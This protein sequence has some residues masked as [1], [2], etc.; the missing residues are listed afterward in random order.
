MRALAIVIA[1]V[2]LAG[3]DGLGRPI[4][5]TRPVRD[6]GTDESCE[7]TPMCRPIR[8]V[9]PSAFVVPPHR[10]AAAVYA[11]CDQD[12][13]A[14]AVD[15]CPGVANEDQRDVCEVARAECERLRSGETGRAYAD[16]RG[17]RLEGPTPVGQGFSLRGA[18]LQCAALSLVAV[19]DATLDLSQADLTRASLELESATAWVA[20]ATRA[21]LRGTFVRL[22]GGARLRAPDAI[23]ADASLVVEPSGAGGADASPAVEL[24]ASDIEATVIFEARS[25]WPG[26]VRVERSN[27]RATTFDVAV[28]DVVTSMVTTSH[29]AADELVALDADFVSVGVRAPY[30]AL[31]AV[32]LRDVVFAECADLHVAASEL[33]DV[34]VPVCE[35]DRFRLI[36]TNARGV[37]FGGGARMTGGRLA[38]SV[39][40]GGPAS[41]LL[42]EEAE[43]DAVTL[44][45]LGAAAFHGG[46]LRCVRCGEDAFMGGT[47]V[48]LSG[49]H[50][51]ERGCPAIEFAP[52]CP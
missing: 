22:R 19:H 51:F 45:D 2:A 36:D 1:C 23:V 6:G 5:G 30:A 8:T 41:V 11:D 52:E 14:D 42:T 7:V 28:L 17:C 49:A 47:T 25:A 39:V 44:C 12:G 16:L 18:Q 4:V 46:Q 40:G 9:D 24:T 35:P 50:I 13:I 33:E 10:L 37:N 43:L 48:C 29:V 20:D 38:A 15:N 26:R 34:D 27:V 21:R 31:S 3:C 32:R